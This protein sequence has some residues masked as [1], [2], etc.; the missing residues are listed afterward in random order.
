MSA[1]QHRVFSW[2]FSLALLCAALTFYS[3]GSKTGMVICLMIGF[4]FECWFWL[5]LGKRKRRS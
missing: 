1:V 5:R 2:L 3:F 4:V